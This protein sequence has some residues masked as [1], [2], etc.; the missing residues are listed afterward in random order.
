[1]RRNVVVYLA[2]AVATALLIAALGTGLQTDSSHDP[3]VWLQAHRHAPLLQMLDLAAGFLFVVISLYGLTV[4]R[5]QM[6]LRHQTEDT[7]DQMQIMMHRNDELAKVN[8]E[9]ADQIAV[10]ETESQDWQDRS[11]RAEEEAGRQHVVKLQRQA[12]SHAMQL[13]SVHIAQEEQHYELSELRQSVLALTQRAPQRLASAPTA[14][15]LEEPA[16]IS[17]ALS[18]LEIPLLPGPGAVESTEI[19]EPTRNDAST[20]IVGMLDF[21]IAPTA[22]LTAQDDNG[23]LAEPSTYPVDDSLLA[24]VAGHLSSLPEPTAV[25]AS[26]GVEITVQ[27]TSQL[28]TLRPSEVPAS[29]IE[30]KTVAHEAFDVADFALTSL[31]SDAHHALTSLREDVD[32][33]K[34]QKSPLTAAEVI[35][36]S[37]PPPRRKLWHLRF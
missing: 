19:R 6:N 36:E 23:H 21:E 2:A 7:R 11:Q 26:A 1:M 25:Q 4:S 28:K 33:A 29:L 8:D 17:H 16:L 32:A 12:E 18:D 9:Y 35:A 30:K 24:V 20:L 5:L 22:F 27:P 14:P 10:M 13:E 31:E 15:L 37:A 3:N 34:P